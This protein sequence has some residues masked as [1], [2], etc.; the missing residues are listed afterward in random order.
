MHPLLLIIVNRRRLRRAWSCWTRV[1]AAASVAH[2][3]HSHSRTRARCGPTATT[4][5][6]AARRRRRRRRSRSASSRSSCGRPTS[7]KA[8]PCR[9]VAAPIPHLSHVPRQS[10]MAVMVYTFMC[11]VFCLFSRRSSVRRRR[12]RCRW[13]CAVS[14]RRTCWQLTR[15]S[16]RSRDRYVSVR[17]SSVRRT[18]KHTATHL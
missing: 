15:H 16:R 9:S 8:S 2:P 10:V 14:L 1:C 4:S 6:C 12:A 5:R 3:P 18:A 11:D 7:R 17:R 13:C